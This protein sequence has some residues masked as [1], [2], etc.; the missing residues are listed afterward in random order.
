MG[1]S[2]LVLLSLIIN[3][4]AQPAAAAPTAVV[5]NHT[6]EQW[7]LDGIELGE[8]SYRV[9][10][11]WGIPS[12]VV[13]DDWQSE[14]ETWNYS[15]VK[16]VGICNGA[17]SFVQV[18]AKA[19]KAVVDNQVIKMDK[20]ELRKALGKPDFVADDGWLVLRGEEALKVF[21]NEQG[22]LVSLDLFA[23]PDNV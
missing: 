7:R 18:M 19:K 23:G 11:A 1:I 9:I 20:V 13:T 14:C 5:Y 17:V 10:G 8:N 6:P 21:V 16:R 22:K 12:N 3:G 2:W 15:D 4:G